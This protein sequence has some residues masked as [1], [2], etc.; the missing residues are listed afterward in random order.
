MSWWEYVTRTSGTESPKA[1]SATTG[2]D[3]PNFSRWKQGHVPKAEMATQFARAYGRPAIEALVAAGF[4]TP[5]EAKVRP[6]AAP[7]YSQLSNDDLLDLV[8]RRMSESHDE[9][10][11]LRP[12]PLDAAARRTGRKSQGQLVRDDQDRQ[13]EA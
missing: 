6:A 5:E 8:R 1:M 7:D 11:T 10:T 12:V 13:G 3:G 9:T 4:L 2:I